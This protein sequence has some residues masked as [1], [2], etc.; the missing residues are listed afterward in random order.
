MPDT[1]LIKIGEITSSFGIK[2]WLKV[3]SFTDE[4]ERILT[5][6]PWIIKKPHAEPAKYTLS[7]GALHGKNVIVKLKEIDTR[8]QADTF[9]G[10]EIFI[11]QDQL[12]RPQQG[13]YYWSDLIGMAVITRLNVPLGRIDSMLE[14]GAND[15]M[16]VKGEREH[17]IP[18]IHTQVI[19]S[20]DVSEKQMI[21]EWDPEF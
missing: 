4:R 1:R 14:T 13:E 18:F 21:V 16:I 2:G 6:S 5:F 8:N 15:V 17:A 20:I 3:F 10:S 12:P 11:R 9:I 19:I 7:D